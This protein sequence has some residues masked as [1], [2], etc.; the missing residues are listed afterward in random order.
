MFSYFSNRIYHYCINIFS[1]SSRGMFF[2]FV[3]NF[4]LL[5]TDNSYFLLFL[6]FFFYKIFFF[7]KDHRW[8]WRSLGSGGAIGFFVYAYCFYF[9][10]H[11]AEMSGFLQTSTF[12]GYMGLVSFAI[13]LALGFVGFYSSLFFVRFVYGSIHVD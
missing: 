8:W 10:F 5:F 6:F 13:F 7:L 3:S 1:I 12:F 4:F 9:Y 2:F 11:R